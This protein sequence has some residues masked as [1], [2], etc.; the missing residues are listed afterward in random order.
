MESS[1]TGKSDE[2]TPGKFAVV[3]DYIDKG[4]FP[5]VI[6]DREYFTWRTILRNLSKVLSEKLASKLGESHLYKDETTLIQYD[7]PAFPSKAN[8]NLGAKFGN[9]LYTIANLQ[10]VN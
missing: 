2:Y 1:S 7:G 9:E 4:N 6:A 5:A 10:A 8:I 3:T